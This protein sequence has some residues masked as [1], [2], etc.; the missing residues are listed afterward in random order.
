[1]NPFSNTASGDCPKGLLSSG[2]SYRKELVLLGLGTPVR[3]DRGCLAVFP[4]HDEFD[5]AS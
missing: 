2:P 1:M 4:A 5:S 3:M